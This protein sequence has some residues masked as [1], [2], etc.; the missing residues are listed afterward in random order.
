M[1]LN[2]Y[3]IDVFRMVI[4]FCFFSMGFLLYKRADRALSRRIPKIALELPHAELSC[5]TET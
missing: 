4:A 1:T 2:G 5:F 3:S